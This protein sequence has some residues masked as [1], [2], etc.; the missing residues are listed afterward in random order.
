VE[1]VNCIST[2]DV[3]VPHMSSKDLLQPRQSQILSQIICVIRLLG[4]QQ[5]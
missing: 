3:Y 5:F 1:P 4:T 2:A